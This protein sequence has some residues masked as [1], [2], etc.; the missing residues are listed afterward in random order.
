MI[1]CG[2]FCVTEGYINKNTIIYYDPPYRAISKS[3]FVSY[4]KSGFN[5]NEQIRLA[6]YIKKISNKSKLQILSNSDPKNADNNDNFF[7][8]LY[9]NFKIE[10]INAKR[11]I[12]SDGNKRGNIS[13]LLI[14][15]L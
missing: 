8:Y 12:N 9:R 6:N 4:T 10:R 15:D 5:D 7:D 11:S 1:L 13:E 14:S 2:D 3:S